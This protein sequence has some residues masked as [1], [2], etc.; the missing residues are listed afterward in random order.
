MY[1][2][3][4]ST[5]GSIMRLNEQIKRTESRV[6]IEA[7]KVAEY[8]CDV[9]SHEELSNWMPIIFICSAIVSAL[10]IYAVFAATGLIK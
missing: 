2:K 6:K 7:D 1:G 4:R 10:F 9:E 5:Q 3:N 8:G